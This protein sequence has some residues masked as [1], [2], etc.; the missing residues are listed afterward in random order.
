MVVDVLPTADM[1]VVKFA[2]PRGPVVHAFPLRY[3]RHAPADIPNDDRSSR[4]VLSVGDRVC[5]DGCCN[6]YRNRIH[7]NW[8]SKVDAYIG[9]LIVCNP[10]ADAYAVKFVNSRRVVHLPRR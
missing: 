7:P 5:I 9:Q 1:H 2:L 3:I 4:M 6:L 10:Q 8:D